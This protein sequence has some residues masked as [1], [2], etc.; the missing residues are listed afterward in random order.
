MR[1]S[2]CILGICMNI[3][4]WTLAQIP[5]LPTDW[6]THQLKGKPSKVKETKYPLTF[7]TAK[8]QKA[9]SGQATWQASFNS[10]G[11][12]TEETYWD[13]ENVRTHWS[14]SYDSKGQR[15]QSKVERP[16][17]TFIYTYQYSPNTIQVLKTD[18]SP[19]QPLLGTATYTF[20][21]DNQLI[22][23]KMQSP[24]KNES[25][26]YE[27][28]AKGV[29]L[30]ESYFNE[31]DSL[32]KKLVYKYDP[33]GNL[34]RKEWSLYNDPNSLDQS[35]EYGK[36]GVLEKQIFMPM[37]AAMPFTESFYTYNPQGKKTSE[38]VVNMEG[39]VTENIFAYDAKGRLIEAFENN[40]RFVYKYNEQDSIIYQEYTYNEFGAGKQGSTSWYE[41][42]PEGLLLR[43]KV[44]NYDNFGDPESRPD[45]LITDYT[46]DLS[47]PKKP[48]LLQ[49]KNNTQ[50][51]I[52]T[53]SDKKQLLS[54]EYQDFGNAAFDI[55]AQGGQKTTYAYHL[56]GKLKL[57]QFFYAGNVLQNDIS[58]D[59]EGNKIQDRY[60]Y[61]DG[62]GIKTLKI[63]N[64][65][66]Y[67]Y[68]NQNR[69]I[70]TRTSYQGKVQSTVKNAYD[71]AGN[72]IKVVDDNALA[73]GGEL[74]LPENIRN[75]TSVTE[76]QY[77]AKRQPIRQT[78]R[79]NG[80]LVSLVTYKYASNDSIQSRRD[81]YP[82]MIASPTYI[83]KTYDANGNWTQRTYEVNPN[84]FGSRLNNKGV[85]TQ[86]RVFTYPKSK[87]SSKKTKPKK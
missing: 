28:D 33:N 79:N 62:V 45:T 31:K 68:D 61:N 52:Y 82:S 6:E 40:Q 26:R 21:A 49:I 55:P 53:Y 86:E 15:S 77:N 9:A 7:L 24:K 43:A 83:Y 10:N 25:V 37:L 60:Y 23:K 46:Y 51:I 81:Y 54:I 44:L 32:L 87:S 3:A 85:Y 35:F 12:L 41:F 63:S 84:D 34:T 18:D 75:I 58:Y 30:S 1:L 17:E 38:K 65:N 20:S 47:D 16:N 73:F 14:Y 78:S 27:R 2:T 69:L 71:D 72:L 70:E 59:L 64:Q 4:G 36:K 22:S 8:D 80:N 29:L 50:K 66:D 56:N 11:Y 76:T 5:Q 57:E 13:D 42:S 74:R 48:L 67:T 39:Y 19:Q